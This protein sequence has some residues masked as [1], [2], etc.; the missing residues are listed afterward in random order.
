MAKIKK[1]KKAKHSQIAAEVIDTNLADFGI[2]NYLR[3]GNAVLEDRAIPDFRDGMNPVNRRILWSAY[4]LGVHSKANYVKSARI[5]GDVLGRFHPH[6]DSS[7]YGAMVGMTNNVGTV[8]NICHALIDGDGNWGSLSEPSAAA[9]RYTEARLSTFAD[10][11]LFN[12]FYTPV[13]DYVP[14]YDSKTVEPLILPALLP[15]LLLNGR[16]GIAPGATSS[17]PS[18]DGATIVS[19]LKKIYS[20]KKISSKLLAKTLRVVTTFGGREA[21]TSDEN[22]EALF[23]STRGSVIC[24]SQHTYD[25]K[26][27]QL[28]FTTFAY[29][30]LQKAIE[31]ISAFDGVQSVQDGSDSSD[32]YGKLIVNLK[33]QKESKAENA[34]IQK[35]LDFMSKRENFVLNFTRRFKDDIGQ[36]AAK[37]NAWSLPKMLERWVS[38]R[39]KLEQRACLYWIKEDEKELHRLGL[40]IQAVDLIDFIVKILKDKKLKTNEEVYKSYAKKAKV[41]IEDAKYVLTRPII[42]LRN[43]ERTSLEKKVKEVKA[44][45]ASL[46]ERHDNPQSAMLKQLKEFE[47]FFED[48]PIPAKKLKKKRK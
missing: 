18:F 25:A 9:M 42:T 37:M 12:R 11:V 38:W 46:Q 7:V 23:N 1:S 44:N 5:V 31:R 48:R 41:A 39:T 30:D 4:D 45:K 26:T 15:I 8:N 6:G 22:R 47:I 21:E 3:Y 10:A 28:I 16:F 2:E 40:L 32:K 19:L 29:T 35:C 20:G 13:I 33:R 14:N 34:V 36:S 24:H 27:R 17:I 43:L